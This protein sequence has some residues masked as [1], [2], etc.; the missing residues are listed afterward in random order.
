M[1]PDSAS[2]SPTALPAGAP[3]SPVMINLI[4]VKVIWEGAE[5][6]PSMTSPF[7]DILIR[8][9]VEHP[10]GRKGLTMARA[11]EQMSAPLDAGM[12]I[13]DSDVAIDPVDLNVMVAHIVTDRD[14]VWTARA[15]LWPVSTHLPSWVWGHRKAA[16]EGASNEDII[17][18]WQT[19]IDD[20]D[21]FTFNF[22]YLPRFLI[23]S[24][25]KRGMKKWHYPNVDRLMHELAKELDI[26]VRVVRGDCSPK[27]INFR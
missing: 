27:H 7:H 18:Q 15:K 14:A 16:P 13:L 8:R 5:P 2:P 25:I 20:P 26:R 9:E 10:K 1:P 11:W 6:V 19:D 24:A 22:T 23:E 3:A 4:C 12:L 17:R 21:W